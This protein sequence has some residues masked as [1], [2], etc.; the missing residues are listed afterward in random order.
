[1]LLVGDIGRTTCRLARF[2][3][4]RRRATAAV[5]SGVSLADPDGVAG[6]LA[7]IDTGLSTLGAV[8][9][10]TGVALGVTGAAQSSPATGELGQALERRLGAPVTVASDVVTAHAGA[11]AGGPGVL[12][13]AGTGAVALALAPD[14]SATMVDGWGHLLGD[15]GSATAIGRAGL[16]AALRAHDGRP[17]GSDALARAATAQLG[18]LGDL[19]RT[20]QGASHPVRLVAGFAQ[21]VADCARA[22]DPTA[23]RIWRDAARD[24]ADTTLA[25]CRALPDDGP[26]PLAFTGALFEL[27]D[28]VATPVRAA[29]AAAHPRVDLRVPAGDALDGAHRLVTGTA[30]VH[31]DLV[32]RTVAGTRRSR[33]GSQ[34]MGVPRPPGTR[35][36]EA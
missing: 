18:H 2:E 24:L 15:A 6:I 13:I 19:A 7:V 30:G 33:S 21:A 29:V 34:P 4:G 17:G 25:A 31:H 16:A 3:H 20:V 1:M 27:D 10:L 8:D 28:L 32:L 22:G 14:G 35:R 36:E 23:A 11:F 5:A 26:V 12:T 9:G